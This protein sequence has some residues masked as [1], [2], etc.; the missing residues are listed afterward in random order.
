M[1]YSHPAEQDFNGYIGQTV[2]ESM[3][4]WP[5]RKFKPGAPNVVL[6]VLDDT[7][8]AH[9]GC[10]GSTIATPHLDRLALNGLRYNNFHT[11]A[12][13]SASRACLLTGR[14]HHA[15]GVRAVS[16]LDTGYP[17]SRGGVSPRAATVAEVL[18][19]IGGYG[20]FAA[21][22][23]HL[24]PML[25]ATAAGPFENW[26]LRKGFDRF[27]G[28]LQGET[29]QFNPELTID[30]HFVQ[31]PRSPE[32]GYH[33]SED[34]VDQSMRYVRDMQSLV[35]E[36]PF[37]LYLAFGA[38]HSPHQAPRAY[39]EKYK[40]AFDAGWDVTRE[41]WFAR[42]KE[43]GIVPANTKLAPHNPGVR[44]FAELSDNE[45]RFAC[46]LQEAFAA[47]LEHTDAQI[48]RLVDFLGEMKLLE[49]TL[50]IVVSD[51][52]ASQE[53]GA[54]GTTDEMKT[55]NMIAEDVDEAVDRID[56]IGGPDSHSNIPWGWAQ[57][58]NTPLKWYK[59][60]T[61]GGGVR[62]PMIIHWPK[63]IN[64]RGQIRAQFCHA[65]DVTP[66]ILEAAGISA[67]S[68]IAGADQMA[69]H[70]VSV[71][72][73]FRDAGATL[74]RKVQYFEMLSHRG[75]WMEG[76][77][78]VTHH[79][80]SVPFDKDRWELYNL[81]DDFSECV[82]LSGS[83]TARLDE[84]I[85]AWWGEAEKYGV[86]P[87]D[88]RLGLEL[89]RASRR[90]GMPTSR[91]RF[92]YFPPI[93]HIVSDACPPVFRGWKTLI[94]FEFDPKR[95]DGALVA[96]GSRNSGF[97]IY[98]K[99]GF[100]VFHYNAF[101]KHEIVTA[102]ASLLAGRH[103]LEVN[104]TRQSNGSA[105]VELNIDGVRCAQGVLQRL[106]YIVSSLG[107]DIGVSP[108]PICNDYVAPFIYEAP[109]HSVVFE[110]PPNPSEQ[111]ATMADLA[112][113]REASARQ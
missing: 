58:G 16:N 69:M 63:R 103:Q 12:L 72:P 32:Q 46:A 66:T 7:G 75:I 59:Q 98:V 56:D 5:E 86:L 111:L 6:V 17:N 1:G 112:H 83:E 64:D 90:S 84:L 71:V 11:T 108:R 31:Q 87:L 95:P 97:A 113:M 48:G 106:L 4:A 30:N 36:K 54:L 15:V 43:M 61:H 40:G 26:P 104:V 91:K 78:A 107:M 52:G 94:D 47:M 38:M 19:D 22:K 68:S 99:Q 73:T 109:I 27:Y 92:V 3:P 35:P 85:E 100:P 93:S 62:D 55:F 88:D 29:D 89:F 80:N 96:R 51:N 105:E 57:A 70:G 18:R 41:Q 53:G 21:G 77:K 79:V 110:L 23:W 67:P 14:N 102:G 33:I 60:N 2:A 34:L 76:W 10:F 42:Q 65:I 39:R 82:D 49:N 24:A 74:G 101:H 28:F 9:L 81:D 50:F 8:F 44:P 20:T 45:K 25:E 37:F 13:C